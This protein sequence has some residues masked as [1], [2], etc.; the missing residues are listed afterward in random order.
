MTGGFCRGRT[1]R[2]EL[3]HTMGALQKVAPHAY[4]GAHCNDSAEDTMCYTSATSFDSGGPSF[5]YGNDDYW[6]PV[7]N[8]SLG[9]TRKLGWW[10]VNRSRFVCALTGCANPSTPEY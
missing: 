8:P 9:S 3:G 10:T 2:H 4:D 6:D 1:L 7:A 5:D